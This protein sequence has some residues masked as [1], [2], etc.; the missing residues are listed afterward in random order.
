MEL[1]ER[2]NDVRSRIAAA[3][4]EAGRSAGSVQLVAVSKTFEADAIRPAIDAGQRVF[5]ENRVQE[6]Q[7]KWPTLKAERPDIELHLIGPLQSNKAS[8]AVAL[9]DVIET[10]D[11]EKIARA[12]AEE[13]KRQAKTLRLYVQVNTGL[14]PQKA[15]IAPDDTPAF[16]A[17]CRDELGLSIEGLMCI[18]PAEENPG[19]HFALLV[20]LAPKC[21]V[22]KL[23][24]G[25]SGDYGTAIAFGA[26]SVRVGSAIF[27]TR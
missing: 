1:Q 15:G 19:P 5:G 26:T 13:M 4:R 6:S 10:V 3:E 14:E 11:R 2:L 18:P 7:G 23:S 21:G 20:K 8:D 25:M 17:F 9:F 24:M 27:G 22:E 12:L 16:V